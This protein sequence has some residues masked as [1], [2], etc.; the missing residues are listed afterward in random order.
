MH[1]DHTDSR[2]RYRGSALERKLTFEPHRRVGAGNFR[3][4][5][6]EDRVHVADANR[7]RINYSLPVHSEPADPRSA[8]EG[9][10]EPEFSLSR[11]AQ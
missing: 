7:P 8:L 1:V 6:S 9:E 4:I 10:P 3:W 11:R 2:E 5:E